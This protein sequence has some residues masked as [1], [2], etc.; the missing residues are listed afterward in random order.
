MSAKRKRVQVLYAGGIEFV[1]PYSIAK[2]STILNNYIDL[3]FVADADLTILDHQ[4]GM[5]AAW[6][7]AVRIGE[8][9]F[10]T[11]DE[12]DGFVVLRSSDNVIYITNL[13]AFLFERLGKPVIFTG[14]TTTR[15]DAQPAK[16]IVHEMNIRTNLVSAIQLATMDFGGV[17]LSYGTHGIS[18]VRA[19]DQRRYCPDYFRS[20]H[21]ESE[22]Q[23]FSMAFAKNTPARHSLSPKFQTMFDPAVAVVSLLPG[24]TRVSLPV[25][26]KALVVEGGVEHAVPSNVVFPSAI[27][28]I[29]CTNQTNVT[30]VQENVIVAHGITVTAA[31]TKTMVCLATTKTLAEFKKR[32]R[33]NDAGEFVKV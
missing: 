6:D 14:S 16:E 9:I 30:L 23:T 8:S 26:A 1:E 15:T 10:R 19:I 11:Y 27:P 31:F 18:A 25:G 22:A 4:A 24:V 13:L 5:N 3:Q 17:I 33:H 7:T 12:Y 28:V 29:L 20:V 21:I 2:A 32:F